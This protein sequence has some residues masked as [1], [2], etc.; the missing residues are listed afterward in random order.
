MAPNPDQYP[1]D[2]EICDA[3]AEL[4]TNHYGMQASGISTGGGFYNVLVPTTKGGYYL[5][6]TADTTWSGGFCSWDGNWDEDSQIITTAVDSDHGGEPD[7]HAIASEIAAKL[8]DVKAPTV[9]TSSELGARVCVEI[10]ERYGVNAIWEYPGFI[11]IPC[12]DCNQKD[13]TTNA[14][15]IGRGAE[16]G[17]WT[18]Q[19]TDAEGRVI[20]D[21][22]IVSRLPAL[23]DP[24]EIARLIMRHGVRM[25]DR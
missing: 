10:G 25:E 19:I 15:G 1:T 14:W 8:K 9:N 3:V 18:G 5:F 17:E 4:L 23:D 16:P 20:G 12:A 2:A 22:F 21:G 6:G 13:R 7:L 24:T 11:S